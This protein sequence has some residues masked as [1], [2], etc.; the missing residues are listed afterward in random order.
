[1]HERELI[2]R[3]RSGDREAFGELVRQH[4]ARL[5]SFLACTIDNAHDVYDLAQ[6]AF[7]D[8]FR[9]LDSFDVDKEFY[10]WLRGIARNRMLNFFRTR[11][12]RRSEPQALVDE[13]LAE[14]AARCETEPGGDRLEALASCLEG[15][16]ESQRSLIS[17]RYGEGVAVKELASRFERNATAVSMQLLRLRAALME[18]VDR[19]LRVAGS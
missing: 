7:L 16:E 18:C 14:V 6:D 15:L 11:K 8:A 4:Q 19:K 12:R 17:L 13:A 5:R 3:A 10:P 9:N 2:L 1:M